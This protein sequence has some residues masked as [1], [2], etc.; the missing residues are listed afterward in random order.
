MKKQYLTVLF[1]MV[2]ICGL[3]LGADAKD[4]VV[5]NIPHD[6]VASGQ[7]LPAGSYRVNRVDVAGTPV[8]L[9]IISYENGASAFLT[10]AFF[11]DTESGN[12]HL[13]FEHTGGKYFLNG[14]ETPTGKYVIAVPR[15]AIKIA[16][17]QAESLSPSGSN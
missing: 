16:Q 4:V 14:I 1:T 5:A 11:D 12:L 10:P 7:V 9:Q 17:T 3:A 8:A 6:F 15:L 2:C 13:T